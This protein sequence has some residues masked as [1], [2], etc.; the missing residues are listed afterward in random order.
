MDKSPAL[1]GISIGNRRRQG[2]SCQGR[3]L[4]SRELMESTDLRK[5][6]KK[7]SESKDISRKD[8]TWYGKDDS[9]CLRERVS[10]TVLVGILILYPSMTVSADLETTEWESELRDQKV[11]LT[12]RP[13]GKRDY[14]INGNTQDIDESHEK[15]FST[16]T[17]NP[18]SIPT[19]PD[20][21]CSLCKSEQVREWFQWAPAIQ[22]QAKTQPWTRYRTQGCGQAH[23]KRIP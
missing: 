12:N 23:A 6:A 20:G 15:S 10:V 9:N 8:K 3:R 13:S 16:S 19:F 14:G 17:L 21:I 4:Q 7:Q 1:W 5:R 2:T 18:I 11:N 22:I